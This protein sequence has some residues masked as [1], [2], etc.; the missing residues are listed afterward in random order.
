VAAAFGTGGA[1]RLSPPH[2]DI[3]VVTPHFPD[4]IPA[5]LAQYLS[6]KNATDH[7]LNQHWRS[8]FLLVSFGQ[9]A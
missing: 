4:E 9:M 2:H 3:A 1:V 7:P 8:S 6:M 5:A